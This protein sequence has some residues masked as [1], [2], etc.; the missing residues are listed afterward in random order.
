MAGGNTIQHKENS[1]LLSI[2]FSFPLLLEAPAAQTT[3]SCTAGLSPA[4]LREKP[5]RAR[6]CSEHQDISEEA[7]S[8]VLWLQAIPAGK[9]AAAAAY[10]LLGGREG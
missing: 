1:K 5:T 2:F 10:T 3:F 8:T 6:P 7:N 9:A 4:H